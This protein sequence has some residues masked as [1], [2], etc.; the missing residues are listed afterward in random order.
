MSEF[1]TL[2]VERD[3]YVTTL[4]MNRPEK[5]NAMSWKMFKELRTFFE[6]VA[7][8]PE[9]R[10]IVVTGAAGA[11]CT[12]ADLSDPENVVS[13]AM[14]TADRM[15]FLH[16]LVEAIVDCPKPTVAKVTGVAAG[17]GCNLAFGCDLVVASTEARFIEIF[18]KRGLVVDFGGTWTLTRMLPLNKAK[19]LVFLGD[20]FSAE[21]ADRLGLLNRLCAPD[22]VDAVTKDL[23]SRLSALPPRTLSL[24]KRNM[25]R[26]AD[27]TLQTVLD[28]E[29]LTQAMCFTS[30]DTR[31]AVMAFLDKREPRFT[32]R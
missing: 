2:I 24:I 14:E 20:E 26:A 29:A 30:E 6:D 31:E 15:R 28:D 19:E 11:F 22:E 18:V 17:A 4:T 12:G 7:D 32:G 1:E 25:N 23:A 3:G 9:V 21:E 16:G 8:D 13:T 5:K 10:C 27:G